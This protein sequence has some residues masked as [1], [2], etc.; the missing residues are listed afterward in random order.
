MLLFTK[1]DEFEPDGFAICSRLDQAAP[2]NDLV[3]CPN[4]AF[5]R[6]EEINFDTGCFL[7]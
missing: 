4:N 3:E 7:I 5:R 1:L 2:C 6:K